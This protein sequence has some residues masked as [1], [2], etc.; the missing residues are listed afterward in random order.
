[1]KT[2]TCKELGG[3]CNK[4]FH[5]NSFDEIAKMSKEHGIEMFKQGDQDHILAMERMKIIIENPE[6]MQKW[7]S[8]KKIEFESLEDD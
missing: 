7:M 4:E 8:Q 5:A 3:A 6:N 2:M 1:M